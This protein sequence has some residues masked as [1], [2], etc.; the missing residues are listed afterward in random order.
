MG[1]ENGSGILF[2]LWGTKPVGL[3]VVIVLQRACVYKVSVVAPD[4]LEASAKPSK[5]SGIAIIFK[6]AEK[7]MDIR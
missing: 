6:L 3:I 4:R 1:S 2:P 5:L 7:A